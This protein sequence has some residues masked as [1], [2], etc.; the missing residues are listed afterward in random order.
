[1][2]DARGDHVDVA[3]VGTGFAGLGTGIRLREAGFT[4]FAL[5]ERASDVGGTWRENGY[6]GCRCD[7]PSH[8]YSFSFAPNPDWSHTY[9]PR[10]EI[11]AYLRRCAERFGMLAH[12]R[13]GHDV[14][15]AAWDAAAGQWRIDTAA[16]PLTARVLVAGQG[17]L[18]EPLVPAV[19]GR[20]Q[21]GGTSFHSAQWPDDVSLAG[22]RVAVIG[23][24]ASAIQIVPSIQPHVRELHVFQRTPPWVVPHMGRSI[25][26]A[27]RALYRRAPAAQKAARGLAYAVRESSLPGFV[28]SGRAIAPLAL[29]SRR[30]LRRQVADPAL[31]ARLTPRY[32]IGCKRIV[33]SNEWYPALTQPNVNV[34]TSAIER[35][36][37]AGIATA[38]GAHHDADAIVYATGF[39]VTDLPFARRVVGDGGEVLSERWAGSPQAYKGTAVP[40]F[41]NLFMVLGPNTG[42]GHNSIVYMI[43][44]Q[45]AYLVDA[46]RRMRA[47]GIHAVDV[48]PEAYARWNA[49]IQRRMPGTVW[50][51]GGCASWY[52]DANGLNTAIWPDYTWRFRR[53]TRRFD[54]E[55]YVPQPP[56]DA[57]GPGHP[58]VAVAA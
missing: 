55:A 38:D 3:I 36:T 13:F 51:S 35:V 17:G 30:M 12:I 21:F 49:A 54:L 7:I 37:A 1:M 53:L 41:P 33:P 10:A 46:M 11:R 52:I 23:T 44:S 50:N 9:S 28:G 34:V 29:R 25:T 27:E 4:D 26:A 42:L 20:E 57:V 22:R 47:D 56:P 6:P 39:H 5:L 45:I 2:T 14:R 32:R 58:R 48:R 40:G 8:L 19:P 24:G 18:S 16:G 31:R 15:R 43:E